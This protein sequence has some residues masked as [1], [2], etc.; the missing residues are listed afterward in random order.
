MKHFLSK[1][2][3]NVFFHWWDGEP[4]IS[5]NIIL[6]Q[7]K[8]SPGPDYTFCLAKKFALDK[9]N[10]LK[11][12]KNASKKDDKK[13]FN[14]FFIEPPKVINLG[15]YNSIVIWLKSFSKFFT[16]TGP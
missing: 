3:G 15:Q 10:C 11:E 7:G 2:N 12:K 14:G 13:S 9:E 5:K 8:L 4:S 6:F 1:V 16:Q